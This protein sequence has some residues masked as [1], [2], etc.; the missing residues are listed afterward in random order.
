MIVTASNVKALFSRSGLSMTTL[1][2]VYAL[3]SNE[4]N[5]YLDKKEFIKAVKLIAICQHFPDG[6]QKW[7][8]LIGSA[9]V[10]LAV[11]SHN[12]PPPS[13]EVPPPKK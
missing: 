8:E 13:S 4:Q 11:F 2:Q 12:S 7:T 10:K 6:L 1:M 9:K 5:G 3:A